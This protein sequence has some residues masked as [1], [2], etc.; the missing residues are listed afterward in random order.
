MKG[1]W[2]WPSEPKAQEKVIRKLIQED[3]LVKILLALGKNPEGL[4]NAQVDKSSSNNSQWRT[5]SHL[6]ELTGLGFIEYRIQFFGDPGK[7]VLT[8]LGKVIISK[9][10]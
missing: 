6:K 7:Y 4:S 2:V 5:I 9:I 8:E 10:Q 1:I 3:E